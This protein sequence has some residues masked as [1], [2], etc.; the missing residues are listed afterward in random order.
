MLEY[1]PLRILPISLEDRS[2]S[3]RSNLRLRSFIYFWRS[4]YF[5]IFT[6]KLSR[7]DITL[8]ILIIDYKIICFQNINNLIPILPLFSPIIFS[9]S[10]VPASTMILALPA[11]TSVLVMNCTFIT[12]SKERFIG[13]VTLGVPASH[14]SN[15][16]SKN[17]IDGR[18]FL[19]SDSRLYPQCS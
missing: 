18:H 7:S 13:F 16:L 9:V 10:Y 19:Y 11:S 1:L 14:K 15:S 17:S 2:M 5:L 3:Y 4:T 6:L 12:A 8:L